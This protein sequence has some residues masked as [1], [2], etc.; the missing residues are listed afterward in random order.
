MLRLNPKRYSCI[1]IDTSSLESQFE[2]SGYLD[3]VEVNQ[4]ELFRVQMNQN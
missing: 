3:N 2:A 1:E 4:G